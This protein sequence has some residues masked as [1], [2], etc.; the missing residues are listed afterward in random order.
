MNRP[1]VSVCIPTYNRV[2]FLR[3][4]LETVRRQD[5]EPLEILI[6]DNAS[7]D[8]TP[9]LCR[10]LESVD[11]RVRYLR[12]HTNIGLYANHNVCIQESHGELLC[13]FHDDDLYQPTIVA[14]YVRFLQQHPAVGLVCAD[15]DLIDDDGHPIGRREFRLPPV[16]SG[17]HYIERTMR[18]GRSS[19]G[20][21]GTMVRREALG[22]VRFD[23]AGPIG[24]G[25]FVVWC[26]VAERTA[27]GHIA[28]RLWSYR[29]HRGSSSR[30]T[31]VSTSQDYRLALT[32]YC[33][34][35]LA[36]WPSHQALVS[37]WQ[38]SIDRFLFWSLVYELGRY[39]SLKNGH[40]PAQ[41]IFDSMGYQ[42]SANE[43]SETLTRLK[44]HE[45]GI[46]KP[47]VRWCIDRAVR[48]G[49]PASL[50]WFAAWAPWFRE[51]LIR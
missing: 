20:C 23:E 28:K 38:A 39:F 32:Q 35:H 18:V 24:F 11:P 43:L 36:R 17:W 21:P 33:Q 1:L 30:R 9:Q 41:T 13:F 50:R 40:A 31:I 3:Q 49:H 4:S 44:G 26:T 34:D 14:E 45:R 46:V 22:E 8:E 27:V 19:L 51:A 47:A 48:S 6:A 42:L 2:G 15:W 12:H 7:T 25:D 37:R 29:I 16:M 10:R 5:Y